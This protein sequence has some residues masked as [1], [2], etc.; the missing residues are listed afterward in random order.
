[1]KKIFL[2]FFMFGCL[3]YFRKY[4]SNKIIFLK[5]TE[6]HIASK[7]KKNIFHKSLSTSHFNFPPN[8]GLGY[9]FLLLNPGF[10]S[11]R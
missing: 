8:V 9:K 1:M 2:N 11:Q 3:K 4:F 6:N 10:N 5:F 7:S